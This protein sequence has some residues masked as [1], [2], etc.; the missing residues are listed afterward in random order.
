MALSVG[1]LLVGAAAAFFINLLT[2]GVTSVL[3]ACLVSFLAGG[4]G[5]GLTVTGIMAK[6]RFRNR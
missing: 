5:I 3:T 1:S 4:G 2:G 6:N